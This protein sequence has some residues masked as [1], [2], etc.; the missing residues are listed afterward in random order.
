MTSKLAK[1]YDTKA[2]H[3]PYQLALFLYFPHS[4]MG[5]RFRHHVTDKELSPG[6]ICFLVQQSINCPSFNRQSL[7]TNDVIIGL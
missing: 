7:A 4:N 6:K 5:L 2:L 3:F 1:G